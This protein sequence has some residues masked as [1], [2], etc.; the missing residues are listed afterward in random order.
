[1]KVTRETADELVLD[2]VPWLLTMLLATLVLIGFRMGW[3]LVAGGE[4]LSGLA[5]GGAFVVIGGGALAAFAE[6][7]QLWLSRSGGTMAF[8]R[9]TFWSRTEVTHP[10]RDISYATLQTTQGS[11]G[12]TLYRAAILLDGDKG[13]IA[14]TQS[15]TSGRGPERA[16]AAINR[17]LSTRA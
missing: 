3:A 15:Y 4:V 9:R 14:L 10:M 8:R 7:T 12:G 13:Q 17:W 11:K 1:M 5:L 16:V 2:H 6:R